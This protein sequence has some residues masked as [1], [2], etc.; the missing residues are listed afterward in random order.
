MFIDL[1][2]EL[3]N[4]YSI[5]KIKKYVDTDTFVLIFVASGRDVKR[6][7]FSTEADMNAF[8]DEIKSMSIIAPNMKNLKSK[9]K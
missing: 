8:Y 4:L 2:D 7:V 6:I 3:I 5:S 9:I 1:E